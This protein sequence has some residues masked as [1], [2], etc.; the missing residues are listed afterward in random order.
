VLEGA[1]LFGEKASATGSLFD[2][3][4]I[5]IINN[6]LILMGFDVSQQMFFRGII[7]LTAISINIRSHFKTTI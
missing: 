1:S 2:T 3:I 4:V 5:G 6:G 7:L